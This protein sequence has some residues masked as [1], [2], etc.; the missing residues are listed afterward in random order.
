M[1]IYVYGSFPGPSPALAPPPLPLSPPPP[2]R[3]RRL[4]AMA[5]L[6]LGSLIK[7]F[8]R[9]NDQ[10]ELQKTSDFLLDAQV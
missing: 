1:E 4:P 3:R 2:L 5:V 8:Q 7:D 6:D 10:H 9:L